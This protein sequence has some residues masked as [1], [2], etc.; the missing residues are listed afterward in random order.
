MGHRKFNL[1]EA[2]KGGT[3]GISNSGMALKRGKRGVGKRRMQQRN[4]YSRS[5][6]YLGKKNWS[7][8]YTGGKIEREDAEPQRTMRPVRFMHGRSRTYMRSQ[9]EHQKTRLGQK[10]DGGGERGR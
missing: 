10:V 8:L 9:R 6:H 5:D 1:G 7:S 4:R 2:I 3:H